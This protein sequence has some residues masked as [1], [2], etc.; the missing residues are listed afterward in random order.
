[1]L[2]AAVEAYTLA[3]ALLAQGVLVAAEQVMELLAQQTL[4][5]VVVAQ[6]WLVMQ[7]AM[8]APVS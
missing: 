2:G 1:M 4:A 8:A 5:A 3:E 7:V 6:I